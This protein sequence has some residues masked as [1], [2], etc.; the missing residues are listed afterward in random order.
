MLLFYSP[1]VEVL[2]TTF[3]ENISNLTLGKFAKALLLLDLESNIFLCSYIGEKSV[4][5]AFPQKRIQNPVK[6]G[7]ELYAKIVQAIQYF[8]KS[9]I[10]DMTRFW[11]L[12]CVLIRQSVFPNITDQN[13]LEN[14]LLR[15]L[16]IG[17]FS[18]KHY[19][20]NSIMVAK[21]SSTNFVFNIKRS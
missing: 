19:L 6:H 16:L 14:F 1:Q 7:I 21:E 17:K 12:L 11:I 5:T 18:Q 13:M 4:E 10:F 9:S 15:L 20:I 8:P 2:K 3:K